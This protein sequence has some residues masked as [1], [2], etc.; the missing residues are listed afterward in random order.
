MNSGRRCARGLP[1]DLAVPVVH[2]FVFLTFPPPPRLTL[3]P[4]TWEAQ[5]LSREAAHLEAAR[6]AV[7][8]AMRMLMLLPA[9]A[10]WLTRSHSDDNNRAT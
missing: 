2:L 10:L 5:P 3:R 8:Q 6:C 4:L 7:M 9:L 1:P